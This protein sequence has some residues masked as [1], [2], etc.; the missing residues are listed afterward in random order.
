MSSSALEA[1]MGEVAYNTRFPAH[2]SQLSFVTLKHLMYLSI[3]VL[4]CK[5]EINF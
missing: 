3:M 2:C 1:P 5:V 4:I